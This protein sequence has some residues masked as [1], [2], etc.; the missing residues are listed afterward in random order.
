MTDST[1]SNLTDIDKQGKQCLAKS[2]C[3]CSVAL[4]QQDS[5]T[6]LLPQRP[7]LKRAF[8]Y[9]S[10]GVGGYRSNVAAD[11]W[12]S[13][14]VP[15]SK[16]CIVPSPW[17]NAGDLPLQPILC[18]HGLKNHSPATFSLAY[19]Y[20]LNQDIFGLCLVSQVPSIFQASYPTSYFGS[21]WTW[22]A[23]I[24]RWFASV[25]VREGSRTERQSSTS[26]RPFYYRYK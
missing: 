22:V 2:D 26:N 6:V 9:S 17:S 15:L 10:S 1:R 20:H 19:L 11:W 13:G 3:C 12:I 25:C 18:T 4:Q 23:L 14:L 16:Y 21:T 7:A 8:T 24:V 5:G